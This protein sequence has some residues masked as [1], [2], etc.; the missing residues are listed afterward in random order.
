MQ[1]FNK[2]NNILLSIL[3]LLG[4][5]LAAQS[6]YKNILIDKQQPTLEYPPCEPSICINPA[7]PSQIIA[8]AILDRV[9]ISNDEG[10]TWVEKTMHAKLGVFGDPCII[11]DSKGKFYYFHLA[12]PGKKQWES[13]EL[14]DC[15]VVQ[16]SKKHA[17]KW[18]KGYAI[19]RNAPKDQDKEWATFSSDNK[20]IFCTWTEF[21]EYESTVPT[22]SSRILFSM[23]TDQGKHWTSAQRLSEN[24]GNCLDNDGTVEGAV[25]AAGPD[26]QVYVAWALN[27]NIYFDRSIDGGKTWLTKDIVAAEIKGGWDQ[28][29]P[30][31]FRANGMPVLH[32]DLSTSKHRGALYICWADTRNG[33][34]DTDI[35]I[36]NSTDGGTTWSSPVKVN[37]DAAGRQQFFPWLTIDQTT[38]N[39]YAVFYDRRNYDDNRTDVYLATSIDGGLTW[40]NERI[41]ESPFLPD[42][43]LFFGDYNNISAVNGIV[44]PIWSRMDNGVMSVWTALIKK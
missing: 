10:T 15:I 5:L 30:G 17:Q 24:C 32:C 19:G 25:P 28:K 21:D 26:N 40:T 22:D 34:S 18:S 43:K 9:Y 13:P 29:I 36:I 3:F 23:S 1:V 4:E 14:L 16:S 2:K 8:G 6:Q 7:N 33:E 12:A 20:S 31:I 35:W 11:A 44:R 42:A 38:G 37:N 39:L 41:S 27:E